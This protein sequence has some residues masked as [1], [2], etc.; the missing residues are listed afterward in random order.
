VHNVAQRDRPQLGE[1]RCANFLTM[2][3]AIHPFEGMIA[4]ATMYQGDVFTRHPRLRVGFMESGCGWAPFW[5]E[6]MHEH[7]KVLGWLMDPPANGDPAEIFVRQCVVTCEGEEAMVPYVQERLGEEVVLW[8]SDFPH[9]DT[10]PPYTA[11]MARRQDMSDSQRDG[12]LR[13]AALTFYRLDWAAIRERN[14]ARRGLT[15]TA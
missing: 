5:V 2:H 6:R 4:F 3:A 15:V 14:A 1:D 10:E 7:A 12:V 13:R 9:F 11:D 8:A